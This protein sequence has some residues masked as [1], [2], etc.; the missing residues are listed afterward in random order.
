MEIFPDLRQHKVIGVH[1]FVVGCNAE[2]VKD[3]QLVYA[4]ALAIIELEIMPE[5]VLNSSA[6]RR[7]LD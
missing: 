7:P 1:R 5:A 2:S 6:L 4:E 3:L